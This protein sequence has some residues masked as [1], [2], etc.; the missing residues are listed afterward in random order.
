MISVPGWVGVSPVLRVDY[1]YEG[2]PFSRS[3]YTIRREHWWY[4]LVIRRGKKEDEVSNLSVYTI[5]SRRKRGS[6]P[7][8]LDFPLDGISKYCFEYNGLF[9]PCLYRDLQEVGENWEER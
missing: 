1:L 2:F 9:P 5:K 7:D 4:V 3:K 6:R 8:T